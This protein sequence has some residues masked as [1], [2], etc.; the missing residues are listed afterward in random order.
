MSDSVQTDSK[1]GSSASA[2]AKVRGSAPSAPR[3][4]RGLAAYANV[5]QCRTAAVAFAAGIDSSKILSKTG[6]EAPFGQSPF[7]ISRGN[8]FERLLRKDGYASLLATLSE[9]LATDFSSAQVVDLR[10]GYPPT[11]EGRRQ[12]AEKTRELLLD[13]VRSGRNRVVLD[14]AVFRADVG[15]ES[16]FFEADEVAI[17]VNGGILI[18]EN[19]SWPVIDR[20]PADPDALG[21]ALDQAAMYV[22]LA[23]S[24]VANAGLDPHRISGDVLII[25]PRNT[26]LAPTLNREN[27]ENR[28]YRLERLLAATPKAFEIL[29]TIPN[30][31]SF[32][33]VGDTSRPLSDRISALEAIMQHAGTSYDAGTCMSSCVF[34]TVCRL[35]LF[36]QGSPRIAGRSIAQATQDVPAG[37]PRIAEI[38]AGKR[39]EGSETRIAGTIQRAAALYDD[40]FRKPS[41]RRTRGV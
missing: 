7:A 40:V 24:V 19:K 28:I 41:R 29:A 17:G 8:S 22:L 23:R 16:A 12:R 30:T 3:S 1:A 4:V 31:L 15:G 34:A 38:A 5:H 37:L 27:I 26:G 11:T 35:R 9:G 13:I 20:R 39:P 18:G 6:Y 10:H 32:G 14:G 36:Q 21:A 33:A 25:T 2:I